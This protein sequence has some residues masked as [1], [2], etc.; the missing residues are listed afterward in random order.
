MS[1]DCVLFKIERSGIAG[2]LVFLSLGLSTISA[3]GSVVAMTGGADDGVV[4]RRLVLSTA[5]NAL[6]FG[7]STKSVT[8][9]T[10]EKLKCECLCMYMLKYKVYEHEM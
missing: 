4:N 1:V 2:A 3:V 9:H 6:A 7:I 10:R 5:G 8:P